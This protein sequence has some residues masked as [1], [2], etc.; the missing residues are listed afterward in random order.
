VKTLLL[1]SGSNHAKRLSWPDS[2]DTLLLGSG[3]NHAKRLSWPDS[4]DKEFTD[5]T[6]LDLSGADITHDLE[7]LPYPIQSM[8]FDEIH[9]YEVLEHTGAQGDFR[10]FFEQFN[11]FHR[12][13]RPGGHFCGSVPRVSSIWA[14]GDPGHKRVLPLC[15]FSFL[16]KPHYEQLG[17]T[18]CADYRPWI[19]GWWELIY[20]DESSDCLYFILRRCS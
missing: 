18:A 5:L 11:E 2:P 9:A 12:I 8:S 1:G 16:T 15:V 4:P 14:W 10:F 19:K 6:T 7:T 3:S 17:K 13:L 20:T